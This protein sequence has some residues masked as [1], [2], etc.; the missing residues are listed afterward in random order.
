MCVRPL[1]SAGWE[2]EHFTVVFNVTLSGVS[3]IYMLQRFRRIVGLRAPGVF[4]L[5]FSSLRCV[6]AT[7]LKMTLALVLNTVVCK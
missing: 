6:L 2:F 7:V 1:E 4:L 3:L 5:Y